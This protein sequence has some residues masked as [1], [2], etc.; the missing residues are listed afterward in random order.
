[1]LVFILFWCTL[2][3][4]AQDIQR[5]INAQVWK[6]FIQSFN[7]RDTKTFMDLHSKDVVR[8]P[9][10]A[11]AVWSWSE[12]FQQQE[13]GDN[14][15]RELKSTRQLELRFTERI[16]DNDQAIEVGIYKTTYIEPGGLSKSYYGR[17]H[18]VLRKENNIWKILV[19]TDSS[20][21]NSISEKAFLEAVSME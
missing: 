14:R 11:K 19:D 7:N 5:E 12:Y 20:E 15:E 6:P 18:V 13:R 2:E 16:A 17:F 4:F 8:S 10:D 9:R 3:S 21:A 1:M